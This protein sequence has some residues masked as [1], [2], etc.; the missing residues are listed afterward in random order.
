MRIL[1]FVANEIREH[2]PNPFKEF[3]DAL[4]ADLYLLTDFE[5]YDDVEA[6]NY[7]FDLLYKWLLQD[8][9]VVFSWDRFVAV[10]I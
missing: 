6:A 4:K 9:P 1:C 2:D 10:F 3:R 7:Y 8:N 5:N